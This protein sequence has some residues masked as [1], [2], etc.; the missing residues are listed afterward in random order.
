MTSWSNVIT[1]IYICLFESELSSIIKGLRRIINMKLVH[2]YIC[3]FESDLSSSKM[4]KKNYKCEACSQ[5]HLPIWIV[6]EF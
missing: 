1:H 2:N 3:L 5:L 6:L 4:L